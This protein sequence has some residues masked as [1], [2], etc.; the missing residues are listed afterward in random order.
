MVCF[1]LLFKVIGFVSVLLALCNGS[2]SAVIEDFSSD[3]IAGGRFTQQTSGTESS[4]TWNAGTNNLTA[5][6]DVDN[7]SAYYLSNT[8]STLTDYDRAFFQMDFRIES[9][10]TVEDA[11]Y[12][13]FGLFRQG[14]H[15]N[16]YGTGLVLGFRTVG[17]QVQAQSQIDVGSWDTVGSTFNLDLLV[18]YHLIGTY[19]P[20]TRSLTTDVYN[21]ATLVGTS[22]ATVP[23]STHFSIDQI[24]FENQ[25][26]VV[27]DRAVDSM[28]FTVDNL[29]NVPEPSLIALLIT[30]MVSL[31]L[32][33]RRR[34]NRKQCLVRTTTF[35][36]TIFECS[37]GR[38]LGCR[39]NFFDVATAPGVY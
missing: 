38:Q 3:P 2:K 1:K 22:V 13:Y 28:T 23:G 8:F 25:G 11:P 6:L 5:V 9:Y 29:S 24:G 39:L 10:D 21:G 14:N 34:R 12:A 30:G 31:L 27:V 37:S 16:D 32:V 36:V 17:S 19:D 4:F 20:G 18:S 33:V 15:I 35:V 7:S 26:R